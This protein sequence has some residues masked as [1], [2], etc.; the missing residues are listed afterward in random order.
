MTGP[1]FGRT[2][3]GLGWRCRSGRRAL[4]FTARAHDASATWRDTPGLPVLSNPILAAGPVFGEFF[5][6]S[7]NRVF[8]L[9]DNAQQVNEL[10]ALP[11]GL[12]VAALADHRDAR[13][14]D[15]LSR[16]VFFH[17]DRHLGSLS[18]AEE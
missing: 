9:I 3:R 17:N 14:C 4:I 5:L 13:F 7:G 12:N 15:V 11:A 18:Q 8:D 1:S 16:D 10:P 2:T 6:A